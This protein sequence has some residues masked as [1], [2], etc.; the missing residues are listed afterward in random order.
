MHLQRVSRSISLECPNLHL[1]EALPAE[2]RFSAQRLLCDE[3][4]RSRRTSMDL[5]IHQVMKLEHIHIAYCNT[6]IKI[7]SRSSVLQLHL[8]VAIVAGKLQRV[9]NIFL[10][11][12]VKYRCCNMPAELFC[13]KPQMHLK[14]LTDIHTRRHAHRIQHDLQR[15]SVR[16]KRHILFRKN[17]RDD[18]LIS[19]ATR[20][21]V[22]HIDF[23]FL[24]NIASY[25]LVDSRRKLVP[26]IS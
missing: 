6:V 19:V 25:E 2:L 13:R 22:S 1:S 3:R 8:S 24:R 4:I 15:R 16:H 17:P 10:I 5:V 21:L 26:I 12:S 11:R 20:H 18:T 9:E 23:S 7:L 14:Y